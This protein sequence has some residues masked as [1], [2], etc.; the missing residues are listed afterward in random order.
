MEN[1]INELFRSS[2]VCVIDDVQHFHV[3]EILSLIIGS[4][5]RKTWSHFK[6]MNPE[7]V[8]KTFKFLGQ[9]ARDT[10][11]AD[12]D[13]MISII[14]R[15]PGK[16]ALKF[17]QIGANIIVNFLKPDH[18]F[19]QIMSKR[20]DGNTA[21]P[22]TFL[23]KFVGNDVKCCKTHL[24]IR[25]ALPPRD[26]NVS[27]SVKCLSE[28]TL[29]FGITHDMHA[30]DSGYQNDNGYMAFSILLPTREDASGIENL[31]IGVFQDI[32]VFGSREY[33]DADKLAKR[34][35]LSN[36]SYADYILV[37]QR[38]FVK[39]VKI[40]LEICLNVNGFGTVYEMDVKSKI[41]R[42]PITQVMAIKM[43]MFAPS[44]PLEEE[45][46]ERPVIKTSIVVPTKVVVP[47]KPVAP[48]K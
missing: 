38:L 47:R 12:A 37:G 24:Y 28:K 7:I 4:G 25:L 23:T 6:R 16:N 14:L 8:Y 33:V 31:A 13:T 35:G 19:V 21:I 2:K 44:Q 34:F 46:P 42:K 10:P 17:L 26:A 48:K 32:A 5:G 22:N 27:M 20:I 43:G 18:E 39:L 1:I 30:R 29:K 36:N 3:L 9:G 40:A 15:I 41:I 11:V 45:K